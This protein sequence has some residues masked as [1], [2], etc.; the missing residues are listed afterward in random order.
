MLQ[1]GGW[2]TFLLFVR[3]NRLSSRGKA[4]QL[5]GFFLWEKRYDEIPTTLQAEHWDPPPKNE[6]IDFL[7]SLLRVRRICFAPIL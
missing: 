5:F 2:I 6:R 7:T 3:R 1:Y 4:R